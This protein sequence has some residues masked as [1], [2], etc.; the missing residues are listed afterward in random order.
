MAA[1]VDITV[2]ST[3]GDRFDNPPASALIASGPS[4]VS[5]TGLSAFS[6]TC[7]LALSTEATGSGTLTGAEIS[8]LDAVMFDRVSVPAD[9]ITVV[10]GSSCGAAITGTGVSTTGLGAVSGSGGAVDATSRAGAAGPGS[11]GVCPDVWAV[12]CSGTGVSSTSVA[13]MASSSLLNA[14]TAAASTGAAGSGGVV[15]WLRLSRF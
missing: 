2:V 3:P 10:A 14:G 1:W 11:V 15:P 6:A 12:V 4:G 9:D 8:S 5:R 13:G 7:S